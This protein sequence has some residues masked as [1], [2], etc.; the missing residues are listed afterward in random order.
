MI[1]TIV[2]CASGWTSINI[3]PTSIT[4][5]PS[6]Q[7]P[8]LAKTG[9]DLN[10]RRATERSRH[11]TTRAEHRDQTLNSSPDTHAAASKTE[12]DVDSKRGAPLP[13]LHETASPALH[14]GVKTGGDTGVRVEALTGQS[15]G[16]LN[17]VRKHQKAREGICEVHHENGADK[18]DDAADVGHG[19]ADD[20]G[21]RP[22]DGA[23]AVPVDLALPGGDGR[24]AEDLLEDFEVDGLH[25]DVEVHDCESMLAMCCSWGDGRSALTN[26]DEAR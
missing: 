23:E 8:Y 2:F 13:A 25:A 4:K 14:A 24:E 5:S 7:I 12:Q 15:G 9:L 20:E 17:L 19:G 10:G 3:Q 6:T 1:T 11:S 26:S 18:T 22:V 16:L 21:E